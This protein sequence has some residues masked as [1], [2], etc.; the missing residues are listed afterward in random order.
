MS[1]KTGRAQAAKERS[2]ADA[3]KIETTDVNRRGALCTRRLRT[4]T[5][6]FACISISSR[7]FLKASP[8]HTAIS[9]THIIVDRRRN[10]RVN[11]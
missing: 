5:F 1:A 10:T 8:P 6:Q 11:G 7:E 2:R 4:S 3:I 9:T